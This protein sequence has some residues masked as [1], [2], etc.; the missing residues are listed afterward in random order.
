MRLPWD[1]INDEVTDNN[2]KPIETALH[3]Y[4]KEGVVFIQVLKVLE[5]KVT[6]MITIPPK[7]VP[8]IIKDLQEY[9]EENPIKTKKR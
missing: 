6:M 7:D 4:G 2:I 9:L 1:A 3:H 5:S 8:D